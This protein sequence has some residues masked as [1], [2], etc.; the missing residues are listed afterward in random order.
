MGVIRWREYEIGAGS[1]LPIFAVVSFVRAGVLIAG[2]GRVMTRNYERFPR[3]ARLVSEI[4]VPL[5]AQSGSEAR[6]EA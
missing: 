6:A 4:D 1:V 3:R 2:W 5:P